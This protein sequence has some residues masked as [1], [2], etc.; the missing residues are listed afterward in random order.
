MKK[1]LIVDKSVK[2]L[3][4]NIG[5]LV[6]SSLKL[7][8]IVK[9]ILEEIHQFF[10]PEYWSLLR[11]DKETQELYFVIFNGPAHLKDVKDIRLKL[12]EG[13]AGS[14]AQ[15]RLPCFIRDTSREKNFCNKVDTKTGFKTKSIIAV[16]LICRGEAYGVIEIV[17]PVDGG[18][19][20]KDEFLILQTIADFSAI[21]FANA[22]LYESAIQNSY[23]DSLTGL[24][25]RTKFDQVIEQCELCSTN[26]KRSP[27]KEYISV[28]A[29]DL[30]NFKEINDTYG[31]LVGDDVLKAAAGFFKT[32][33][34]EDDTLFRL[35]GDEF[36]FLI[37]S[38]SEEQL[39]AAQN[40]IIKLLEEGNRQTVMNE[41]T[42]EF[43]FGFA[44]GKQDEI[45][46]LQEKSDSELYLMKKEKNS[47]TKFRDGVYS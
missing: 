12:G 17:N 47:L 46:K 44:S 38:I 32:C 28:I 5:K 26:H 18:S 41:I 20:T 42:L 10:N 2:Q 8:Q 39:A 6:T 35:G 37:K 45:R 33:I 21:A 3:Y 1:E 11:L 13:I 7:N 23:I 25:N 9:G 36:I 16:P 27:E 22:A 43:S 40:R 4:A 19:F 15:N 31:H 29:V 30:N 24:Y 14:V 34:R